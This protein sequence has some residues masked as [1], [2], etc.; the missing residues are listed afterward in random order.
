MG[1]LL[2]EGTPRGEG[3]NPMPGWFEGLFGRPDQL[4]A[5]QHHDVV[6]VDVGRSPPAGADPPGPRSPGRPGPFQTPLSAPAGS[7]RSRSAG[8]R[9]PPT[10]AP[11]PTGVG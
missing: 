7:S 10:A 5:L 8:S 6:H 3:A 9:S 1:K 4:A 11:E 2:A